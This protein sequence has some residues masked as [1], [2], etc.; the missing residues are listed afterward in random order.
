LPLEVT[1]VRDRI[2]N[3]RGFALVLTLLVL[4]ILVIVVAQLSLVTKVDLNLSRNFGNDVQNFYA[5][6]AAVAQARL[7]LKDDFEKGR[8]FD[9]LN[10]SWASEHSMECGGARLTFRIEDEE[11]RLNIARLVKPDGTVDPLVRARFE[12]LVEIVGATP[13]D[14]V[15]RIADYMDKDSTG[16]FE[17]GARNGPLV[18]IEELLLIPGIDEVTLFG[19][20]RSEEDDASPGILKFITIWSSGQVNINTAPAEVLQCLSDMMTPDVASS[21]VA[22]RQARGDDEKPHDFSSVD[23]LGDVPGVAAE[24]VGEMKPFATVNGTYFTVRASASHGSVERGARVALVR[25]GPKASMVLWQEMT[26][27]WLRRQGGE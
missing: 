6:Q 21:I 26:R 14:M 25:N 24:L 2:H 17:S 23:Q 12:R 7:L 5:L 27:F 11:R 8:P 3:R 15:E 18:L 20:K 9:S 10:E 16:D 4:T 1:A 13:P 22:Y 19:G